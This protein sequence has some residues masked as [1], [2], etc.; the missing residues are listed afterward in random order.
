MDDIIFRF[1]HLAEQIFSELDNKSLA[2]CRETSGSWQDV[3]NGER[4]YKQRI[5]KMMKKKARKHYYQR[6]IKGF[7]PLHLAAITGQTQMVMDLINRENDINPS[8]KFIGITPLNL[9]AKFGFASVCHRII[10]NIKVENINPKDKSGRTPLHLAAISGLV[11]VCKLIVDNI[12]EK[13]PKDFWEN[14]PLHHAAKLGQ[15]DVCKYIMGKVQDNN[16]INLQGSTPL[17]FAADSGQLAAFKVLITNEDDLNIETKSGYTPFQLAALNRHLEICEFISEY[18][19]KNHPANNGASKNTDVKYAPLHIAANGGHMEV[20][21]FI[22]E[23]YKN[24]KYCHD[25]WTPLH[26]AALG[27]HRKVREL[28]IEN[29]YYKNPEDSDAETSLQLAVGWNRKSITRLFEK[30]LNKDCPSAKK[31]KFN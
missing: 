12:V 31:C 3:I 19:D 15:V 26:S 18:I 6:I 7:T 4:S 14:T 25:G 21:K 5:K 2:K 13:N 11:S 17:H 9:A 29:T 23:T 20:C 27:G 30:V 22:M 24:P 1:P 16:P 28:L 8:E 10:K